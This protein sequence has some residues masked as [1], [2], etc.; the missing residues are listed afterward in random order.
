[1]SEKEQILILSIW[2]LGI[3]PCFVVSVIEVKGPL[4]F[5]ISRAVFWPFWVIFSILNINI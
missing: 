3:I 1:M 2:G 4:Y 5:H